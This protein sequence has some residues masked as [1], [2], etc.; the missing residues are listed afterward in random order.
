[1][2]HSTRLVA[3][4]SGPQGLDLELVTSDRR[5]LHLVT[6]QVVLA[7]PPAELL[8]LRLPAHPG[9]FGWMPHL[10]T[11][12]LSKGFLTFS[13]PFPAV[14]LSGRHGAARLPTACRD[15]FAG[16]D[17]R[18]LSPIMAPAR[19]TPGWAP[20]YASPDCDG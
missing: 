19:M 18:P 14:V 4:Q 6:G 2:L 15:G 13:E 10:V 1:M 3:A 8:S 9:T 5:R 7:I 16:C 20:R 12:P 11:V 17:I